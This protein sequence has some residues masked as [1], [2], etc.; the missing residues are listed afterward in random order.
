MLRKSG[1]MLL[2]VFSVV[3]STLMAAEVSDQEK[4]DSGLKTWKAL[5]KKCKGNYSY[6]VSWFSAFGFGHST[7]ITVRDNKVI[8]RKYKA[9]G[10][11]NPPN[12]Q[13]AVVET[14]METGKT[15]GSHKKG[16]PVKTLDELYAEAKKVM[17]KNL[18]PR[19]RRYVRLN[20]QGLL[21]SCY[22][23]DTGI[24]D[25]APRNGIQISNIKVDQSKE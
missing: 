18:T 14:W 10:A 11:P 19:E 15:L 13:A 12:A 1:L 16:A 25:D 2:V 7:E 21:T 3:V 8:S 6:T 9:L 20:K 17:E 23:V 22:T 4:F 24:L 5:K